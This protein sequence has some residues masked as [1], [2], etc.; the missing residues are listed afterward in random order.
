VLIL[1]L[2]SAI[3]PNDINYVV[4]T[5]ILK[6]INES[7]AKEILLSKLS[8]PHITIIITVTKN[9]LWLFT[10][11]CYSSNII[12]ISPQEREE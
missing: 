2:A 9:G 1:V 5:S 7:S 4:I 8:L 3:I 11:K 6:Q 12:F 10:D